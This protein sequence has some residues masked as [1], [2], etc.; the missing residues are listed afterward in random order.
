M[1]LA[2]RGRGKR[3]L[4]EV[5][6]HVPQR[7][8]EL[9]PYE[10]FQVREPHGRDVVPERGEAPL[11]FF[12]L[13]FGKAVELDHRDHLAD[14]HRRAAHLSKLFDDLLNERCGPLSLR[15]GGTLGRPDPIGGSHPGPPQALPGH[16]P[17]HA[18]GPR[19]PTGWQ[20]ARLRQPVIGGRTH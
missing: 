16:Q 3:A 17:T 14:L 7:P 18:R 13:V 5:A 10:L 12:A 1:D 15:R 4:V 6:E 9:L 2:D 8:A 19:E 11:Q 20:P